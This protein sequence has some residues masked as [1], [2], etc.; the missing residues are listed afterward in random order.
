LKSNPNHPLKHAS[1]S[2]NTPSY[3][4]PL[5]NEGKRNPFRSIHGKRNPLTPHEY[6]SPSSNEGKRNPFKSILTTQ[7]RRNSLSHYWSPI[8]LSRRNIT[9]N[10]PRIWKTFSSNIVS[11]LVKIQKGVLSQD[12]YIKESNYDF[13]HLSC[14]NQMGY[15]NFIRSVQHSKVSKNQLNKVMN[16]QQLKSKHDWFKNKNQECT[17]RKSK[18]TRNSKTFSRTKIIQQKDPHDTVLYDNSRKLNKG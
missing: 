5:S 15:S 2:S 13:L 6:R 17:K 12:K 3:R 11:D 7:A 14:D 4:S 10:I 18:K 1:D 8:Y 9:K 16:S